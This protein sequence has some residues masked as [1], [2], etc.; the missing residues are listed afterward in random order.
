MSAQERRDRALRR[1][2]LVYLLI[3][4]FRDLLSEI[5]GMSLR[6]ARAVLRAA[7]TCSQTNCGWQMYAL[8]GFLRPRLLEHIRW[9][10]SQKHT[11]A[12]TGAE[13]EG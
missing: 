8:A 3:I 13:E 6:K 10:E 9:L 4:S 2:H 11:P 5:D 7:K 1:R 12:P